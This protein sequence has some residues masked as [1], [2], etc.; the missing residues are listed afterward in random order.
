M[1]GGRNTVPVAKGW[2]VTLVLT[3]CDTAHS[4][5]SAHGPA[6]MTPCSFVPASML[7]APGTFTHGHL[8]RLWDRMC[9][10][11]RVACR[12]FT[13]PRFQHPVKWGKVR[14]HEEAGYRWPSG[15]ELTCQ[16]SS[17]S[18]I[19]RWTVYAQDEL[20]PA[21]QHLLISILTKKSVFVVKECKIFCSW[22]SHFFP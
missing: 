4:W 15:A 18:W 2:Q 8:S 22:I 20:F 6:G 11:G 9:A 7:R 12:C 21:Q 16:F 19:F 13:S 3:W 1:V 10:G 5:P 14:K 17:R